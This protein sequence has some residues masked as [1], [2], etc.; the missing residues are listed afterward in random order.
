MPLNVVSRLG[1][2]APQSVSVFICICKK[3]PLNG[4]CIEEWCLI[5]LMPLNDLHA[6]QVT[7]YNKISLKSTSENILNRFIPPKA[8]KKQV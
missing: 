8:I 2:S 4:S 7:V 1:I 6:L 5:L 3:K